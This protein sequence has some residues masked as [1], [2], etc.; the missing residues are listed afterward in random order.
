MGQK[1]TK[2]DIKSGAICAL[3][4]STIGKDLDKS[5][6]GNLYHIKMVTVRKRVKCKTYSKMADS[7]ELMVFSTAWSNL[8]RINV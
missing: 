4:N 2:I 3:L 1:C 7:K 8:P 5:L 6:G